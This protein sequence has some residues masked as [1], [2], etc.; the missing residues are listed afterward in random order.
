MR[1]LILV[2]LAACAA[3]PSTPTPTTTD[4][5]TFPF[6]PF[7]VPAHSEVTNDCVQITMHN[8]ATVFVNAVELTTGPG[9]H[10]SNWFFV[11]EHTFA[12]DDGT[13]ACTDRNFNE[14]VAAIQGGVLF[15]QSTQAVHEVQQFPA[16]HVVKIPPHSKIVAQLHLLNAGDDPLSLQP[17]IVVTPIAEADV[18]TV[19]AA[20]SFED[21]AIGLP[22]HAQSKFSVECDLGPQHQQLF[23][24]AP[25]FH[26]YYALA[27]YHTLGI[28]L[29]LEAIKPDGTTTMVYTTKNTAGDTLGGPIAPAFDM[30]GYTRLRMSCEYY[31]PR[32]TTVGWGNGD[33]E[34]CIFLAF[35]DS[36]YNWGGGVTTSDPPGDPTAVGNVMTYSHACT[37]FANDASH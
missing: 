11:P 3:D 10:H 23:G 33:Q 37:L 1:K 5:M 36:P 12:G 24:T 27:H 28:G 20:I 17:T 18:T 2:L 26:I 35:S 8:D 22:P 7:D 14:P 25:D 29:D 19:L 13:Y 16:G 30:T 34:M 21:Q 15:A 32:D 31:N 4:P 6:G 9:F